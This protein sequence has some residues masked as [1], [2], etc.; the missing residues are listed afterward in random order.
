M[1]HLS[2]PESSASR[3]S[4]AGWSV[5]R[6]DDNGNRFVVEL[7]LSRAAAEQLAAHLEATGHK[8][9]YWVECVDR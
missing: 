5:W 9:L 2:T 7:G 8:Q 1:N 4:P 3:D 6:Q